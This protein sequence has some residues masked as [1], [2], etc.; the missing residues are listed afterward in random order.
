M[1]HDD[2]EILKIYAVLYYASCKDYYKIEINNVEMNKCKIYLSKFHG[3]VSFLV[4]KL[5]F[6]VFLLV[7]IISSFF[8]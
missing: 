5:T 3:K 6:D 7:Q 1:E 2:T 4:N 8:N